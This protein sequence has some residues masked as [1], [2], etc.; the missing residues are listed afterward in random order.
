MMSLARVASVLA[1]VLVSA[2]ATQPR[3]T[4]ADRLEF[5]RAHAG[6]PVRSFASPTRLWGWRSIGD[7]ALTVWTRRDEG[8]LLELAT[9]CPDMAWAH[10]IG[11]ST[12]TGRVWAGFD[13][14][15]VPR[16]NATGPAMSCRISTIRPLNTRVVKES[17]HDLY[18]VDVVERDPAV[19]GEPQ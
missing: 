12:R 8:Y 1:L 10:S 9:R 7:S 11:L 18:E 3:M 17:R 6:E 13:S 14:I 19:T 4:T 5:Y 2:C 15:T 16:R